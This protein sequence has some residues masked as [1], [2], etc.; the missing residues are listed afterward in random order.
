MTEWHM[1]S[2]RTMTG[3]NR[4]SVR[5]CDKKLAWKGG[6]KAETIVSD[7]DRRKK[8]NAKGS[9]IKV[10]QLRA[11]NATITVPGQKKAIQAQIVAVSENK[12]NR[13]YTRKNIITKG[14]TIRV[15]VDG[16]EQKA[17]ITSRPGQSGTV[18]AVLEQ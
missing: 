12:A 8:K 3:A 5:R 11:K 6:D 4:T 18:Q 14:A 7:T 13:L 16:K 10:K 17:K 9:I 15:I 2:K 1:K